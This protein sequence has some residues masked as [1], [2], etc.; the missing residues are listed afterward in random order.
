MLRR[1]HA[2]GLLFDADSE[3]AAEGNGAKS[4]LYCVGLMLGLPA[5]TAIFGFFIAAPLY[6]FLFLKRI[7]T[8]SWW[9]SLLSAAGLVVFL[10]IM[11]EWLQAR[12]ADGL[13]QMLVEL[14]HPFSS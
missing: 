9:A 11:S 4:T 1:S 7:A 12:Y 6:I 13:L 8:A 3:L 2:P 5:L 10:L 14:P